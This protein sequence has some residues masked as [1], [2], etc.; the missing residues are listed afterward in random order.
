MKNEKKKKLA[1]DCVAGTMKAKG[2]LMRGAKGKGGFYAVKFP[3]QL[4]SISVDSIK[5]NERSGFLDET[6]NRQ[7]T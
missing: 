1:A 3:K 2:D 5:I 7:T 6:P 4:A